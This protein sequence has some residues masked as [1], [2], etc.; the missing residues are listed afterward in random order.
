M[1]YQ[2][3]WLLQDRVI[4]ARLEGVQTIEEIRQANSELK[5]FLVVGK[6]PIHLLL[7]SRKLEGVPL[8]LAELRQSTKNVRNPGVGWVIHLNN[9]QSP[10]LD[11]LADILAKFLEVRYRRVRTVEE[12]VAFLKQQDPSLVWDTETEKIEGRI[13]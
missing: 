1:P 11:F 8:N 13:P 12:A 2:I 6:P 3:S 4:Y 7:D 5:T 9:V 10:L